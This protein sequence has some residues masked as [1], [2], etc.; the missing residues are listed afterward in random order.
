MRPLVDLEGKRGLVVGI[1]NDRSIAAGCAEAFARCGARLAATY[2]NEKAKGWVQPV[3]DRLGV[4]WIT[5]CDVREPGQLEAL[6]DEVRRKWGGLD[7]L[8]HSI[9]FAP[10]EDLHGRVVDSSAEGFAVAMDV[11]CHSF[12]RMAKL[13]GPLMS[14]GGCLLCVTFYGSERVVEHYNLMGPVKAA[15]ESATRYVAAELGP[16]GIRAHAISP[17]PIATRAASG[18]ERFDE[19]IER[20][21]AT[22][23]Q[24]QLIDVEDVGALAAFLVSDA[25]KRITGTVIPVDSGQHLL[26]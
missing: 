19:L 26:A 9:A 14:A 15:L 21:A 6:F 13:A 24:R 17:G 1:A 3:A 22:V 7:F 10:K 25:A 20:A 2:L 11:S 5:P 16:K 23:P 18:I 12:L 8:L 4:E